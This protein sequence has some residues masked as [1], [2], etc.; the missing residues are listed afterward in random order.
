MSSMKKMIT[1]VVCVWYGDGDSAES[2]VTIYTF[3]YVFY[4]FHQLVLKVAWF[5]SNSYTHFEVCIVLLLKYKY[6][7][8]YSQVNN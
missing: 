7:L 4:Q 2:Y 6:K 3:S 8:Q 1:V 5:R